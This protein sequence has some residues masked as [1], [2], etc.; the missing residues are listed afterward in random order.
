MNRFSYVK[1]S[2]IEEA[3]GA[4]SADRAARIIA[5]GTNLVDLMKYDV[6]RPSTVVDINALPLKGVRELDEG[7]VEIA[8]LSTN[9]EI[10]YH[11]LIRANFPLLSSAILAG[12]SPQLRNA[13][14][15]AGNLGQKTRC[16]YFYD[17]AS[18]CNKRDPGTGCS[19]IGGL[20]RMH[21]ILGASDQ[22]IA[23]HPS[24]MCVALAALDA[25]V[26]VKGINGERQ[27]AFS[28]FH[29]LPGD[30]PQFDN[31]LAHDEVVV[32]VRLPKC[33]FGLNHTYVKLRDRQ[34]YAF[35]LVSIAAGLML[36][37]GRIK[38]ASVA[39]GGVAHK[40]WRDHSAERILVGKTPSAAA[41]AEF[42]D[43]FLADA[44]GQGDN[45]FKI[46]LARRL[47]VRALIQAADGMPQDQSHK[48][49][50]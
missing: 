48:A 3:I 39:M 44:I 29:R 1:A 33:G 40:P 18:P 8:A 17:P 35:A 43:A 46:P 30:T 42:A 31:I 38:L 6:L 9:S 13:A 21:A 25:E 23:T 34:S 32:A 19:A 20:N 27:I 36:D 24:D 15:M 11:P 7:A 45:D 14:T 22:C 41:F 12:A 47:L 16:A 49:I 10:A 5:G 50:N 26:H 28:E 2:T 4:L 37:G